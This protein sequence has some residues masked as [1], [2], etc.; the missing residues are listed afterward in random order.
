MATAVVR[1]ST[2]RSHYDSVERVITTMR[3]HIGQPLSLQSM[4]RV[5]CASPFHF[6]RT[7]RQVTGVPPSQFL[8]ALRLDT[9]RRLL[10][11]TER[12]VIDICYDVGYNSVGTFTRRFTDLFG[13]SPTTLRELSQSRTR[14]LNGYSDLVSSR[15]GNVRP[16]PTVSGYVS[17]PGDFHGLIFVGLFETPIP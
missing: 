13:I 3:S 6:N 5:A 1:D 8:Y 16:A 9:A 15:N 12:K 4:A 7:F 14:D 17:V 10:M 11:K 2:V